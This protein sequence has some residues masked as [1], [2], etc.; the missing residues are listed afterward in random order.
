MRKI[1]VALLLVCCGIKARSQG[2]NYA[3]NYKKFENLQ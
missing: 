2:N 3:Q 1:I